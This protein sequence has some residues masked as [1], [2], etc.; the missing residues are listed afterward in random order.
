MKPGRSGTRFPSWKTCAAYRRLSASALTGAVAETHH[1][2]A[3]ALVDATAG[4]TCRYPA[5][6]LA[7][8][9]EIVQRLVQVGGRDAA[10]A[11]VVPVAQDQ[12][13]D[14]AHVG[15]AVV[16]VVLLVSGSYE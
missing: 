8:M 12:S 3:L 6:I 10:G 13:H 4:G 5:G 7:A 14:T 1:A 2:V 9:L 15:V 11:L 16:V